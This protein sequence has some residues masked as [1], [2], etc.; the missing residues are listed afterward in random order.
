MSIFIRFLLIIKYNLSKKK[1]WLHHSVGINKKTVL[2]GYNR[3]FE[4]AE[5]RDSNIGF[6]T[7]IGKRSFLPYTKLGKFCTIG[8]DVK[9]VRGKHPSKVFVSIHPAFYSIRK[10]AGFTFTNE[11]L[12]DEFTKGR[13]SVEIGNDVWIGANV[14][15]I[16]GV[17]IG[18]GAIIGS[19]A[20]VSK[21]IEP[22]SINVGNPI[23]PLGYRFDESV[24]K[25]LI[26][27]QW[28]NK[29][30]EWL[31]KNVKSFSNIETFLEKNK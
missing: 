21:D 8:P 3:I 22:Y 17:K 25:K 18:D 5:I 12:F 1:Y 19:G 10:Q 6:G 28:W 24:I 15:I 4:G 9:L 13:Y 14:M 20:V 7:Y 11:N 29:D 23:K 2:E 16:E 31:I 30:I 27:I 26:K